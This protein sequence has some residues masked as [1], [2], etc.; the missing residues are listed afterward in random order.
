MVLTCVTTATHPKASNA[1]RTR[2]VAAVA[3]EAE[4]V[5]VAAEVD[6]AETEAMAESSRLV[7]LGGG[8]ILLKGG[9]TFGPQEQE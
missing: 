5:V 6:G 7:G 8:S 9:S 1:G 4:V 3:S 2:S